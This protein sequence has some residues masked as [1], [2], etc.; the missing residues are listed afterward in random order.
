MHKIADQIQ[1]INNH[2]MKQ[3][4]K[5]L[6]ANMISL[7]LFY[8]LNLIVLCILRHFSTQLHILIFTPPPLSVSLLNIYRPI[9]NELD[10]GVPY[11]D[12]HFYDD[13][14]Y[15]TMKAYELAVQYDREC[16]QK[17]RD[18]MMLA[19]SPDTP[20]APEMLKERE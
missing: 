3:K 19:D 5:E 15:E 7:F 8:F 13:E 18:M 10:L 2:F 1:I 11:L 4:K 17:V 6:C 16:C 12:R 20:D 14:C 9:C